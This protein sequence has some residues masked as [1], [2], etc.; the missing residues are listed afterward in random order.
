MFRQKGAGGLTLL[1]PRKRVQPASNR[2][3]PRAAHARME[4]KDVFQSGIRDFLRDLLETPAGREIDRRLQ[5]LAN[6]LA[7][8]G[9]D[10]FAAASALPPPVAPDERVYARPPGALFD[11]EAFDAACTRCGD[12]VRGCPYGVLFTVGPESGPVLE[13]NLMACR[14]CEDFPC[15]R[16][17][18]TGALLPLESGTLPKF[19]QAVLRADQCLNAAAVRAAAQKSPRARYCKECAAS[20]PVP[21]VIRYSRKTRTPEFADHCTGC[22]QCVRACPSGAI[23]IEIE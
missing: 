20:C 6:V 17:C 1:L 21:D 13:P 19:G 16:A 4:R 8:R 18:E 12:C 2:R 15:I 9:L 14:L 11:P 10:H 5:G 3:A 23:Q 7:P 22:G